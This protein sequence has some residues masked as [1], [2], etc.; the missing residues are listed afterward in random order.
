MYYS[1]YPPRKIKVAYMFVGMV[2]LSVFIVIP[3]ITWL[4]A[5]P[6]MGMLQRFIGAVIVNGLMVLSRLFLRR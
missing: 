2:L 3:V 5:A 1:R 6:S 4:C